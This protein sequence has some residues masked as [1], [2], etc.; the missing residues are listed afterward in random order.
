MAS[1]VSSQVVF[2]PDGRR[3]AIGAYDGAI[4]VWEALDTGGLGGMRQAATCERRKDWFAAAF[5]LQK[6]I[7][8]EQGCSVLE[9]AAGATSPSPLGLVGCLG[10]LENLEGRVDSADLLGR[11]AR[12][13]NEW[14]KTVL[15]TDE[16]VFGNNP[17]VEFQLADQ[18]VSMPALD[19]VLQLSAQKTYHMEVDAESPR[20]LNPVLVVKDDAGKQLACDDNSRGGNSRLSF[21]PPKDGAYTVFAAARS[22]QGKFRLRIEEE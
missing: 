3:L 19:Y 21:T 20:E 8:Q 4:R 10:A 12:A 9:A 14:K 11:L 15:A 1:G 5:H 18:A 13:R 6:G 16:T 2:S 17:R 7:E 22:G